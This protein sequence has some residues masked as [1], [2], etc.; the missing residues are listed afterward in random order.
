MR[1]WLLAN[2]WKAHP[3]DMVHPENG[4]AV[5]LPGV[6]TDHPRPHARAGG[7]VDTRE[8][9]QV[10]GEALQ[11]VGEVHGLRGDALWGV[12][13]EWQGVATEARAM[14]AWSPTADD[15]HRVDRFQ[16]E[17]WMVDHGWGPGERY[18]ELAHPTHGRMV[19]RPDE[20]GLGLDPLATLHSVAEAHGLR[21][22]ALW[23]VLQEWQKPCIH[24]DPEVGL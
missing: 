8:A 3:Y 14:G 7:T 6:W 13:R 9:L 10:V 4:R 17:Q 12:L 20:M 11:V 23:A 5:V 16:M 24:D 18:G 19:M 2:G 21:G 15:V 1:A 22:P